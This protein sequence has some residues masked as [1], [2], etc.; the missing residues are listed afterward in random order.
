M[1]LS[2]FFSR[3]ISRRMRLSFIALLFLGGI[4]LTS[5]G[6]AQC[7]VSG[8]GDICSGVTNT[9]FVIPDGTNSITSYSWSLSNFTATA[10][11]L[12]ETTNSSVQVLS[13]S[14]GVFAL[15]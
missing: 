12:T 4:G 14:N 15:Q 7:L 6:L 8:P 5:K 2:G 10:I 3:I 13:V 1:T 9:Y 11:F